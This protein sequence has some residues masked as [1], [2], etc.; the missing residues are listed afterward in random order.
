MRRRKKGGGKEGKGGT[1]V[2]NPLK[3]IPAK[4]SENIST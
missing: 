4:K 3:E 2:S 1:K